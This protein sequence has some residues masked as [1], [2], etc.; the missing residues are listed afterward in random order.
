M[1][2]VVLFFLLVLTVSAQPPLLE[3]QISG[4]NTLQIAYPK[5]PYAELDKGFKFHFHVFNSN[6]TLQTNA[7]TDCLFHLYNRSGSHIVETW[8][9]FDTN[10]V[11]FEYTLSSADWHGLGVYSY[12]VQCNQSEG[13]EDGWASV[14]FEVTKNGL[15]K[16]EPGGMIAVT[17]LLPILLSIILL[18]GAVSLGDSHHAFKI[19]LFI[20]AFIPLFSSFH[21]ALISSVRFYYFPVLENFIGTTTYWISVMLFAIISYFVIYAFIVIVHE[22]AQK[23]KERLRY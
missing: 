4:D 11:D 18:V 3:E 8:L 16:R 13:G 6:G 22:A 21:I 14:N 19:F 5:L 12:I 2:Y 17:I 1:Y 9:N 15:E 20:F 10:M 7:T 23:R